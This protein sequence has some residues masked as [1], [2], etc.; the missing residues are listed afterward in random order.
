[1]SPELFYPGKFDL[2][3][4]RPTKHSD[5]YA[6][7]MVIYEVLSGRAPFSRH[8]DLT[9]IARVLEGER[10]VRPRGAGGMRFTD[11]V[12]S[13]LECC[14]K[15]CPGDRPRIKDVLNCLEKVS[16]SWT[17][18]PQTVADPSASSP[19]CNSDSSAEGSG[20]EDELSS[21]SEV[22]SSQPSQEL[23]PRGD[24]NENNI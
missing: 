16:S 21:P 5:C 15:P 6:L 19:A 12:W 4:S 3:D 23:L 17:S 9:V 1:M 2:K 7:G 20:D 10:P 22:V 13:I 14:W 18:P 24:P 8:P 11:D